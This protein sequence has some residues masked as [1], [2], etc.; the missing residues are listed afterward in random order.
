MRQTPAD[1]GSSSRNQD[2]VPLTFL[3]L[4][5]LVALRFRTIELGRNRLS[6]VVSGVGIF[7]S[8]EDL[9]DGEETVPDRCFSQRLRQQV[10]RHAATLPPIPTRP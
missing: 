2:C 8:R 1:A 3:H 6:I 10:R 5:L 9:N 7:D 4:V